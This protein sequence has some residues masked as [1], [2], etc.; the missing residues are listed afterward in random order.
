LR[1]NVDSNGA[2]DMSG[3]NHYVIRGGLAGRERLRF[4]AG[5][6]RPGT[7]ALFDR[8]GIESGARCLDVG[9]GGGDVTAE[10]ARRVGPSGRVLGI[11]LDEEKLDLAQHEAAGLGL[12]NVTFQVADLRDWQPALTFD[13]IYM[14]FVLTHL[15]DPAG[16]AQTLFRWLRPGGSIIVED[17]DYDGCF[18]WPERAAFRRYCEMYC[19]VVRRR[20]GDAFIGRRLPQLLL[21]AGFGDVGV[22]ISQPVSLDDTA[23]RIHVLTLDNIADA[24]IESSVASRQEIQQLIEDLDAMTADRT[25]VAAIPRIVQTWGRHP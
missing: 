24:L 12:Q 20:G 6:L 18:V 14:R 16:A 7:D 19:E 21:E 13:V 22:S 23:K 8:V 11:D 15:P 1:H 9:C 3:L 25:V 10:L 5:V 2:V 17:I 4:I